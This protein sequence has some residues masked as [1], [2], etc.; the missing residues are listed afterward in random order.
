MSIGMVLIIT[1][2]LAN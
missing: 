2:N 1:E